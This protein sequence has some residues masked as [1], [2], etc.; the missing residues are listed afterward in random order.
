MMQRVAILAVSIA[1]LAGCKA[2]P[3][4][5]RKVEVSNAGYELSQLFT[6]DRGNTIYRFYDRG[7]WRYYAVAPDGTPQ[8]LPTTRT[9]RD[10]DPYLRPGFGAGLGVGAGRGRHR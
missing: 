9:I 2:S 1:S 7:D 10:P 5:E 4:P 8:M 6:D 3:Q